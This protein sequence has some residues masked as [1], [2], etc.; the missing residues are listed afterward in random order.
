VGRRV[1]EVSEVAHASHGNCN[2]PTTLMIMMM[3]VIM[4]MIM[5]MIM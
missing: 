5:I 3:I 2:H 4:M 1:G